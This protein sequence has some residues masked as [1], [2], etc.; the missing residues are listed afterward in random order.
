MTGQKKTLSCIG[1]VAKIT[2]SVFE[3]FDVFVKMSIFLKDCNEFQFFLLKKS[4][5]TKTVERRFLLL[6]SGRIC[7]DELTPLL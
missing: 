2:Y 3:Y 5:Q 1:N 6:A 7:F 4:V